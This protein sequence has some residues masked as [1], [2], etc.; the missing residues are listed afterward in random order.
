MIYGMKHTQG[1]KDKI[2]ASIKGKKKS[3]EH[4]QKLS[5]AMK[6]INDEAR[7]KFSGECA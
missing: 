7:K 4:R 2:S 1:T 3:L 5:E 6:R